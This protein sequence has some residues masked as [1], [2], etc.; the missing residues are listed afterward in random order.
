MNR[1][2]V[3]NV[4]HCTLIIRYHKKYYCIKTSGQWSWKLKPAKKCVTTYR[5]NAVVLKIN[6]AESVQTYKQQIGRKKER[7]FYL[8]NGCDACSGVE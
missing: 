6:G 4:P 1:T 2:C 3:L 7:M 8:V 5:T